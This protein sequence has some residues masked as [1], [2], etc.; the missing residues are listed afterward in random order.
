MIIR[1]PADVAAG[2]DLEVVVARGII[3]SRVT[4]A[5]PGDMEDLLS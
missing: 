4:T 3:G 2:D 5:T 1:D